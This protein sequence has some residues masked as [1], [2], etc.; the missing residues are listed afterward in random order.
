MREIQVKNKWKRL[1]VDVL[2]MIVLWIWK[3]DFT[4]GKKKNVFSYVEGGIFK[5]VFSEFGANG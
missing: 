2:F 1:I 5:D 4:E 3:S